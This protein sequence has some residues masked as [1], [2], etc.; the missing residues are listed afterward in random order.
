MPRSK[1]FS[2]KARKEQMKNKKA[3]KQQQ[4]SDSFDYLSHNIRRNQTNQ[5]RRSM[6]TV[7]G[8]NKLTTVFEREPDDE[9]MKRKID[10]TRRIDRSPT[11][12]EEAEEAWG[13]IHPLP[14]PYPIPVEGQDFPIIGIPVRPP[15][16]K[17]M[18]HDQLDKQEESSFVEWM[19][20]IYEKYSRA[21]LN[22]FEHN[23]EVWRQIWRSVEKADIA[24]LLL[25]ARIPLFHLSEGY[26]HYIRH[27]EKKDVVICI[28]KCDLIHP[29]VVQSWLVF[30]ERKFPDIPIVPFYVP[31]STSGKV[32]QP[33]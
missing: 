6:P 18:S 21:D 1:P 29:Y 8:M 17:F 16:D 13:R 23:L 26:L 31:K 7:P 11:K 33:W 12:V 24:I 5:G 14:L 10:S 22:F 30:L 15:W 27:V 28:N 2:G 19:K 9:V 25:D 3:S 32:A 4:N 20:S